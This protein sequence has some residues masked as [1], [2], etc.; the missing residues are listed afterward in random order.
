MTHPAAPSRRPRRGIAAGVCGAVLLL[1]LAVLDAMAGGASPEAPQPV[2]SALRV[3]VRTL[4][5]APVVG[6]PAAAAYAGIA[7]SRALQPIAASHAAAAQAAPVVPANQ[8]ETASWTPPLQPDPAAEA[9]P[10]ARGFEPSEPVADA[11]TASPPLIAA[12]GAI[13]QRPSDRDR[14]APAP[15]AAAA[16]QDTATEDL[17]LATAGTRP[18]SGPGPATADSAPPPPT[19]PTRPPPPA[20][21]QF[22]LQRGVISGAA[23][24]DWAPA[25]GRYEL[26]LSG[27][28]LGAEIM[29]WSSTGLIDANG[30][31]PVRFADKRRGRERQVANFQREAGRITFSG[32]QVEHPLVPGAQD[33]LSFM[34]QLASILNADPA[35][36][37]PGTRLQMFV[38]GA[39]GDG[40]VWTFVVGPRA[41]IELPA[42]RVTGAVSLRRETRA[43]ND[44]QS[45]VWL[46]PARQ[47]LPV[48][49]VMSSGSQ[50]LELALR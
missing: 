20:K 23:E 33:R 35:R 8:V 45:E 7:P 32:P 17:L 11:P 38:A 34:L 3:T 43:E 37:R 36:Y 19:Y 5:S 9:R 27:S 15:E 12:A 25:A 22:T 13:G 28:V 10:P 6:G 18:V 48:R 16:P 42:G 4:A 31:A 49:L 30:I 39:R 44:T 47:H 14:L 50:T 41:T 26:K 1:H 2:G 29:D 24:L 46:D 21:L 40:S